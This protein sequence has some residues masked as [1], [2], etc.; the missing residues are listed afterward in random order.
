[1]GI[2]GWQNI[3][4]KGNLRASAAV[5]WGDS[6][7][8]AHHT[9][10]WCSSTTRV[11]CCQK[12]WGFVKCGTTVH[13][14]SCGWGGGGGLWHPSRPSWHTTTY[15]TSHHAG[16]FCSGRRTTHCRKAGCSDAS[17]QTGCFRIFSF[18][19]GYSRPRFFCSA[20]LLEPFPL[21]EVQSHQH[22]L[23]SLRKFAA[24][25]VG[26]VRECGM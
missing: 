2:P 18:C 26:E 25:S 13:S 12:S 5:S 4:L 17:Q 10:Y 22:A 1:M 8:T 21:D 9:G 11:R 16:F 14:R 23:F 19:S 3:S 20:A 24:P 7:C 15:C 6:F